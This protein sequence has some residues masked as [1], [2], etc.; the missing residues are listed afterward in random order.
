[1][2]TDAQTIRHVLPTY[3]IPCGTQVVLR[4]DKRL[5]NGKM[6]P[7]GSVAIVVESPPQN[8]LPYSIRFAN[9][10]IATASFD[11]LSLRRRELPNMLM[12]SDVDLRP[13]IIYRCQVGSH[14]F[15]LATDDSD[16][17]IRGAYLP[18]ARLHWSLFKLPQQLE[19]ADES[20]DEVYWELEKLL[21]LGLQ[22]NPNVLEVLWTPLV[23]HADEV[24]QRL[25]AMREAFLSKHL[26]KTYSAYVL[27]QFRRMSKAF[28]K[29]GTYKPKHAMHLIRLLYSGVAALRTGTL[30]IGVSERRDE[31][32]SIKSGAWSFEEAK[33][34]ALELDQEF[35]AAYASTRLPEQPDY[36]RVDELLI[37]ARRR[38]VDA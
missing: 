35:Q 1:M 33:A 31:L 19:F 8:D 7:R 15:G 21:K 29:N 26:Y 10:Q 2:S 32:L 4:V 14:A 36:R 38:M 23:L 37:W 9:D 5:S 16:D 17:D 11:E 18:P 27:S 24:A 13:Y 6:R 20:K 28:A 30:Q 22:A 25:L 12:R 3:V 34:R